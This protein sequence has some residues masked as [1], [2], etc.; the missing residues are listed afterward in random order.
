[1]HLSLQ[2]LSELRPSLLWFKLLASAVIEVNG[3]LDTIV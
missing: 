3:L 1:M 2:F